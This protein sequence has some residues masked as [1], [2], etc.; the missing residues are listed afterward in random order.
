MATHQ[1]RVRVMIL[2]AIVA[3]VA[4]AA[5]T[6]S[7]FVAHGDSSHAKTAAQRPQSVP[8]QTTNK[9]AGPDQAG[10]DTTDQQNGRPFLGI[11]IDDSGGKLNVTAVQSGSPA[12]TAGVKQGDVIAAIDGT[13][14]SAFADLTKALNAKKPGDTVTLSIDRN[15]GKQDITVT[16]GSRNANRSGSANA[17]A[18]RGFLGVS[19]QNVDDAAKQKY[20]LNTTAGALVTQVQSGGPA[21]S[22]GLTIG[23]LITSVNNNQVKNVDDLTNAIKSTKPGD[24]AS[25]QYQ[26]SGASQTASITL[27]NGPQPNLRLPGQNGDNGANGG[28]FPFL[29]KIGAALG[30][31]FDRFIS[32]ETKTKDDNGAM[33]TDTTI[34][35]TVKSAANDQIAITPNGGGSDQM[36]KIDSTTKIR[37]GLSGSS[38]GSDLKQGDKVLVTT[39]DGSQTASSIVD[40]SSLGSGRG[41]AFADNGAGDANDPNDG[42]NPTAANGGFQIQTQNGQ[43]RVRIPGGRD[44]TI[45][46]PGLGGGNSGPQSGSDGGSGQF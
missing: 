10:A 27:G 21:D 16:L 5:A 20:N 31:N 38:Q 2:G 9:P 25:V 28:N 33:H 17:N 24:T 26:R 14:V 36:F 18:S 34:G 45:P 15:G 7:V 39:R 19:V 42:N 22:A 37:A 6:T 11:S 13:N 8:A 12:D 43:I 44:F 23:D 32:S 41:R 1:T 40:V 46:V 35:G 30:K 4:V 3:V 29:P